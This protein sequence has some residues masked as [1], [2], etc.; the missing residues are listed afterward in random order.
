MSPT[1]TIAGMLLTRAPVNEHYTRLEVSNR[2]DCC[3]I[4]N[5][6]NTGTN[7]RYVL[8]LVDRVSRLVNEYSQE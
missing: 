4:A 6:W 5:S 7:L 2:P 1:N 8:M 3:I